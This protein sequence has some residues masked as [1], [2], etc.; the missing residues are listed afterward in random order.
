MK[1]LCFFDY[2]LSYQIAINKHRG[3]GNCVNIDQSYFKNRN[4]NQLVHFLAENYLLKL[5]IIIMFVLINQTKHN[6]LISEH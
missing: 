4:R 1:I 6:V 5:L 3:K 2:T